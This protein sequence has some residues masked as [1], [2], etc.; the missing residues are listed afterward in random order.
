[1]FIL[2]FLFR[3]IVNKDDCV[4]MICENGGTCLDGV[5]SYSC[6]CATGFSGQHCERKSPAMQ[7]I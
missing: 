7:P 3:I 6:S 4:H 5:A 1:M 2:M